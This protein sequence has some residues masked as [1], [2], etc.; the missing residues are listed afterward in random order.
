MLMVVGILLLSLLV[1]LQVVRLG[2][3]PL[4]IS[5]LS[6]VDMQL[7]VLQVLSELVLLLPSQVQH[8]FSCLRLSHSEDDVVT[9]QDDS[10]LQI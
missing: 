7:P 4:Q 6:L 2:V 9:L 3:V 5:F 10:Q 8:L 1:E